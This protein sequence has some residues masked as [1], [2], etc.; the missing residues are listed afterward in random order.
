[1]ES[2]ESKQKGTEKIDTPVGCVPDYR[3]FYR[4]STGIQE[5]DIMYN[6]I[7]DVQYMYQ[8]DTGWHRWHTVGCYITP[9]NV[10]AIEYVI[11]NTSTQPRWAELLVTGNF[12][13][14]L[15]EPKGTTSVNQIMV[16]LSTAGIKVLKRWW[17]KECLDMEGVRKNTT[18]TTLIQKLN[19]LIR[20]QTRGISRI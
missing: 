15:V 19:T 9:K 7:W 10:S 14:N 5:G 12:N 18:L 8:L 16:A 13:I 20:T 11:V 6:L 3:G 1:M 2:H 4:Q 17:E